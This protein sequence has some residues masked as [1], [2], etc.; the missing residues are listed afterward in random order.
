MWSNK[1]AIAGFYQ[2]KR[3]LCNLWTFT[4]GTSAQLTG[5]KWGYVT[6]REN[7]VNSNELPHNEIIC[8]GDQQLN[9]EILSP[10]PFSYSHKLSV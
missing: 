2:S 5:F 8:W 3:P 6:Q 1:P 7:L 4:K 10:G 9:V